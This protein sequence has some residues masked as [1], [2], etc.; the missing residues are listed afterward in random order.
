[1]THS[2][3]C[4]F[5]GF[6]FSLLFHWGKVPARDTWP[7]PPCP[8]TGARDKGIFYH[9]GSITEILNSTRYSL[10]TWKGQHSLSSCPICVNRNVTCGGRSFISFFFSSSLLTGPDQ[11]LEVRGLQQAKSWPAPLSHLFHL[12]RTSQEAAWVSVCTRHSHLFT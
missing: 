9:C 7:P 2:S 5:P 10:C 3:W 11:G 1:M 6:P 12:N 4:S 8:S